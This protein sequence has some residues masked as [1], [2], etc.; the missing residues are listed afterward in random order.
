MKKQS[1]VY[2]DGSK[3]NSLQDMNGNKPEIII[4]VGNRTA[5]KT[6]YWNSHFMDKIKKKKW[7]YFVWL[8]RHKY[9]LEDV[10]EQFYEPIQFRYP[11]TKV[12]C[13]KIVQRGYR[14]IF[15]D[16]HLRGFA[17]S[18][19][20]YEQIKKVSN[21][22]N[23]VDAILWDEFQCERGGNY[24]PDEMDAFL[25][26][27]KSIA[28]GNGEM[29]RFVPVYCVGNKISLL[30]PLYTLTDI[31]YRIR[32][33]TKFLRGNGYVLEQ[34]FNENAEK[35]QN[36]SIFNQA[37]GD[38]EEKRNSYK[39]DFTNIQKMKG[40]YVYICTFKSNGENFSIK[41]YEDGLYYCSENI[42]DF[43]KRRYTL[44]EPTLG[45][46]S[47]QFIQGYRNIYNKG[48]FRFSSLKSRA[49]LINFIHY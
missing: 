30:A 24:L 8:V 46:T 41:R 43:C 35:A 20:Y 3:L 34:C 28:R 45:W 36:E 2:Y 12:R 32:E 18:L 13:G 27:H 19:K 38:N 15:I 39:E 40:K 47:T 21:L 31:S 5:G 48:L 44:D 11:D 16:E 10:V 26:I 25:S 6:V 17:I 14:E 49:A 33:D 37:L 7:R 4:C 22:F 1:S 9:E 29:S 42:D 23:N